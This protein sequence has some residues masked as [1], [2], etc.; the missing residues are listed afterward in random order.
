MSLYNRSINI[1]SNM[2]SNL[3]LSIRKFYSFAKCY[4]FIM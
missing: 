1:V 3:L 2:L 4:Y